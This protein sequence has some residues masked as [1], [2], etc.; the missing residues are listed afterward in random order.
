MT[1]SRPPINHYCKCLKRTENQFRYLRELK[2][3][4]LVDTQIANFVRKTQYTRVAKMIR[5]VIQTHRKTVSQNVCLPKNRTENP[6]KSFSA[7]V[8]HSKL[9]NH[10]IQLSNNICIAKILISDRILLLFYH[11]QKMK[12]VF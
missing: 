1:T 3:S 8:Y 9:T 4:K 5:L 11:S 12:N 10:L 2:L 6:P 7:T